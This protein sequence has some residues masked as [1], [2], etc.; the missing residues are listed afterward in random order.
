MRFLIFSIG[1]VGFYALHM[2]LFSSVCP[3]GSQQVRR[4]QQVTAPEA[5][6]SRCDFSWLRLVPS[7]YPTTPGENFSAANKQVWIVPS[8]G[9]KLQ[10]NDAALSIL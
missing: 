8:G 1:R 9:R 7:Y 5:S 4:T 3:T 2:W 10:A 6:P